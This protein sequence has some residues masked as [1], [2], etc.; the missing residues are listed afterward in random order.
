SCWVLPNAHPGF[1]Q[2][3]EVIGTK[4]S[5]SLEAGYQGVF[6]VGSS[7]IGFPDNGLWPT[8]R[9]RTEGALASEWGHFLD[10]VQ[11]GD[12]PLVTAEDG[13]AAVKIAAAVSRSAETKQPVRL[14]EV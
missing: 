2:R 14:D 5:L 9:G 3:L 13:V 7:G 6:T 8:L 11:N 4:G 12:V 1:D 10:C